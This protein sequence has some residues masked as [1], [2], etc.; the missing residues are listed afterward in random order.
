MV[1]DGSVET[2]EWRS[3]MSETRLLRMTTRTVTEADARAAIV[4]PS[5]RKLDPQ[6]QLTRSAIIPRCQPSIPGRLR[7]HNTLS[8]VLVWLM[9]DVRVTDT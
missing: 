8:L 3:H 4:R 9:L 5:T 6:T 2:L 1:K 7:L